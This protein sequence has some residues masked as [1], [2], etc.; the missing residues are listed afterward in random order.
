M[1]KTKN[2]YFVPIRKEERGLVVSTLEAHSGFLE[3]AIDFLLPEGT[4]VLSAQ[5]GKVV[6]VKD[7]SDEGGFKEKYRGNKHL[8]Y[9]TIKHKSGEYS[10]YAHLKFK[11]AIVKK[12]DIVEAGEII[13]YSGNTGY[14]S[15]PHLHFHVSR[16]IKSKE[17]WET[18]DIRFN[19]DIKILRKRGEIILGALKAT[20]RKIIAR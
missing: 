7:S 5:T 18:M 12:G 3:Y 9:I 17:G 16:K 8:N 15:S 19:E 10:Q 13:G 2:I 4:E 20:F 1:A 14:S 11:G 6:D